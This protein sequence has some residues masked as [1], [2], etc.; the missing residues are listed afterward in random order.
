MVFST[1]RINWFHRE[2]IKRASKKRKM[3]L[4]D[5]GLF[6]DFL[7]ILNVSFFQDIDRLIIYQSTSESNV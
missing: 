6:L 4:T 1:D 7:R 3:K 5:T 2:W